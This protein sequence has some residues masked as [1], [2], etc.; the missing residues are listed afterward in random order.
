MKGCGR[1]WMSREGRR[2]LHGGWA[3]CSPQSR[4]LD[5]EMLIYM[6]FV[7]NAATGLLMGRP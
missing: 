1:W 4:H 5:A 7:A 3:G 6:R 2:L